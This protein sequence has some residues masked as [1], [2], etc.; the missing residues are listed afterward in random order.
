MI[1]GIEVLIEKKTIAENLYPTTRIEVTAMIAEV[2]GDTVIDRIPDLHIDHI[3][4]SHIMIMRGHSIEVGTK[5]NQGLPTDNQAILHSVDN[6]QTHN[7]LQEIQIII[8]GTMD[9]SKISKGIII[10]TEILDKITISEEMV[11]LEE[12]LEAILED[13]TKDTTKMGILEITKIFLIKWEITIEEI[14]E[15]FTVSIILTRKV[16]ADWIV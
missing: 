12:I 16:Q 2:Q 15:I 7:F 4:I 8:K 14:M 9:N 5:A 10:K 13:K 6:S 3:M 11:T 1:T